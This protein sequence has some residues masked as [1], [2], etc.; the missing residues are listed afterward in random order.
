MVGF[1]A[2]FLQVVFVAV[3]VLISEFWLDNVRAINCDFELQITLPAKCPMPIY[4]CSHY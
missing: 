3:V 2:R 1:V 4:I